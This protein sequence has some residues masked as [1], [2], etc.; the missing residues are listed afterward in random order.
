MRGIYNLGNT[1]Y[2]GAALHCL[3]QQPSL[4]NYFLTHPY[5]GVCNF[6]RTF[7][8]MVRSHWLVK[9]NTPLKP[10]ILLNLIRKKYPQFNGPDQQDSQE[11]VI[12]ILEMLDIQPYIDKVTTITLKQSIK[13]SITEHKERILF[14]S[15]TSNTTIEKLIDGYCND[16]PINIK[17]KD[18]PPILMMSFKSY[19]A[20]H[21]VT[22]KERL[23]MSP[24]VD[25]TYDRSCIYKLCATVIHWGTTKSGHYTSMV[26]HRGTWYEKDD[27]IV[28]PLK[29]EENAGH[30]LVFFKRLTNSA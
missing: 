19:D 8:N 3:F 1:C 9:N 22:V 14:L 16:D 25:E 26:K 17:F 20:K 2:L 12:C 24:W 4:S 11:A 10:T 30:Y 23:D 5:K 13:D 6:T 28:R 7:N 15:P 29:Y 21:Q 27:T 18:L